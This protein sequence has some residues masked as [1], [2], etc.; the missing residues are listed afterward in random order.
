MAVESIVQKN[1]DEAY[2][3]TKESFTHA[4]YDEQGLNMLA[5]IYEKK[6]NKEHAEKLYRHGIKTAENKLELL[7]NYHLFLKNQDRKGDARRIK[8]QLDSISTP[9]P[10]DW[11]SLGNVAYN[12]AKYKEARK[13][14]KR[15]VKSAPYLHQAQF[16]LAKAEYKLGNISRAKRSMQRAKENA[17]D[18][19]LKSLYQTKLDSLSKR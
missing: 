17:L 13:Y 4:P 7:R 3:L 2:W 12:Q 9:N 8:K 11:I 1:Y 18:P 16:A 14:Y 6:G 19:D 10:F 15:A 5:L